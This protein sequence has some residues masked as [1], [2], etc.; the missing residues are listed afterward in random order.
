M[1]TRR[2]IVL[3]LLV[4]FAVAFVGCA[5]L[6]RKDIV[7]P[8]AAAAPPAPVKQQCQNLIPPTAKAGECYAQILV[9]ERYQTTTDRVLTRQASEKVEIIPAKY[10]TV[11]QKVAV[12]EASRRFEETPA[13]YGWVEEKVLVQS[14]HS[15]WQKGR[16]IIE[17]VD[18][19]TGDIMCLVEVPAKY[20]TVK[21]QVV[22]K[23]ASV[24]VVEIPAEYQTI[25][26]TKMVSPPQEK[27]TPIAE[28]Y[29]TV[30]RKVKVADSCWDWRLVLCETNMSPELVMKIQQALSKEGYN[31]GAIDGTYGAQTRG[32]IAAYQKA[33]GLG[34]GECSYETLESLGVKVK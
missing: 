1:K 20:E 33:K 8:K 9:P 19:T 16:G 17:K 22:T 12:R 14:A 28:E 30:T 7:A 4:I 29:G 24:R 23:P 21:R 3:G 11:E 6:P 10:E 27:R 18:N 13:E 5:C 31:P 15:E 32:A 2:C 26:V 34:E 25:K